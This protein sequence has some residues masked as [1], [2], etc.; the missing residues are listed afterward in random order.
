MKHTTLS[1]MAAASL[2]LPSVASAHEHRLFT[3]D[4]STY[5]VIVGSINEPVTVDVL[6]AVEVIVQKIDGTKKSD[7]GDDDGPTGTPVTGLEKTLKVE[8]TAGEKKQNFDLVPEDGKEGAY[9]ATFIPTVETTYTYRVIGTIHTIP[10]DASYTCNPAG[11]A[12]TADDTTRITMS[13]KV[14]QTLKGG[15]FGCPIARTTLTFPEK[16]STIV[17]LQNRISALEQDQ[18]AHR[19]DYGI[20]GTIL[21]IV[22]ISM[23]LGARRKKTT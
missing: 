3:I 15:S 22:S 5:T 2:L 13:D 11:D 20:I 21:G 8:V 19:I 1:L 7:A 14:T 18:S 10:F 17:D 6:S 9:V 12:L 16:E 4:G 23:I